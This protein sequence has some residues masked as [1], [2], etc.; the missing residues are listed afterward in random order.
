MRTVSAPL[1]SMMCIV[2][3][4]KRTAEIGGPSQ[5]QFESTVSPKAPAVMRESV[6]AS[7]GRRIVFRP[8]F[9]SKPLLQTEVRG[10]VASIDVALSCV[11]WVDMMRCAF[12]GNVY[13]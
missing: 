13:A 10:L 11:K 6:M 8:A 12:Y 1:V 2:Q 4:K 5:K 7:C 9:D 3:A